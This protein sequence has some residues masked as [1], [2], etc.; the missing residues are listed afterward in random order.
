MPHRTSSKRNYYER[1]INDGWPK[2]DFLV[3]SVFGGGNDQ[4]TESLSL[5]G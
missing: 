2:L 4:D 5:R 1:K 3:F